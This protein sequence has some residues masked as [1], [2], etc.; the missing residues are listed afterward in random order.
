MTHYKEQILACDFFTIETIRLQTIYVLFFIE[1]GTRR[2]HFAGCTEKPDAIW[3]TQQARQ[4]IWD[5]DD[6]NQTFRFLIHDHDTKF[7]S[8]FDN[9]FFSES[10]NIIHTPFQAPKANS[11]AERRVRSVREECLDHILIKAS[12]VSPGI[13]QNHLRRVLKEYVNYYNHH[14]PHQGIDQQFPIFRPQTQSKWTCP[15]TQ[16]LGR[17]HPRLPSATIFF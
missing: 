11:F 4:L 17:H 2:I 6:S 14:R 8:L 16:Y 7:S 5:L 1:L 13:D 12:P 10:I 15:K 3:V 9:V